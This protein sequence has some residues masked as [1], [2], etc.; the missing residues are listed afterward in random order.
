MMTWNSVL[1]WWV[2]KLSFLWGPNVTQLL[3]DSKLWYMLDSQTS[4]LFSL[5]LVTSY[6]YFNEHFSN[7]SQS[8]LFGDGGG[9]QVQCRTQILGSSSS[10]TLLCHFWSTSLGTSSTATQSVTYTAASLTIYTEDSV[11]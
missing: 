1:G 4:V 6:K 3:R 5:Y 8:Q 9:N 2:S 10:S 7:Q 11:K